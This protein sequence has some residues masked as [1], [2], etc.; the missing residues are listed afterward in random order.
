MATILIVAIVAGASLVA[1]V[2]GRYGFGARP[3]DLPAA[4]RGALEFLGLWLVCLALDVF[5]GVAIVLTWRTVTPRFVSVYL[6]NDISLLIF[7]A[8]QA[9]TLHIWLSTSRR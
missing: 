3:R 4:T 5:L 8:V 7:S 9:S 6:V 2:V 1:I